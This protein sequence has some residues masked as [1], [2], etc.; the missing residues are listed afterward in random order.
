MSEAI[1]NVSDNTFEKEVLQETHPVLVDYW[2]DWC[3]PCRTIAPALVQIAQDYAGHIKV[4]KLNVDENTQTTMK[5][6]I[7]SIPTLMLFRKGEIIA[8]KVGTLSKGQLTS[9][10]EANVMH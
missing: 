1:Y 5:Y 9:F 3:G 8:T 10:I 7:R 4:A 6:A 2:A